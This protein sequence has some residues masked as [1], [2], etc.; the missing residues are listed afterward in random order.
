MLDAKYIKDNLQEVAEKLATRGYKLDIA[1]FEA[2]EAQRKELQEKTQDL[3][4]QRNT[5]SKRDW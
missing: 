2:Q 3:Q 5:I 4:A 1:D